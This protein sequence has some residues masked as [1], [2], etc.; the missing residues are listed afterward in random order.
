MSLVYP[1]EGSGI[2]IPMELSGRKGRLVC[3]A[4]HRT[5]DAAIFLHLDG[6]YLDMTAGTHSLAVDTGRGEHVLTLMEEKGEFLQRK[7]R[8]LLK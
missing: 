4:A 8:V 5:P 2:Y 1:E 3:E 7:F 6:E